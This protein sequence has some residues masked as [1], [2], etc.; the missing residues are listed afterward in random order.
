MLCSG[1][2][3]REKDERIVPPESP[4]SER[5]FLARRQC[6]KN[7]QFHIPL[8]ILK[9]GRVYKYFSSYVYPLNIKIVLVLNSIETMKY[10]LFHERNLKCT[11]SM[12]SDPLCV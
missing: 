3:L 6:N 5:Q 2:G 4:M 1:Y 11:S 8:L 7:I 12:L 10:F 9:S